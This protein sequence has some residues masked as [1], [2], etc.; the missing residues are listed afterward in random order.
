MQKHEAVPEEQVPSAETVALSSVS[1]FT[2]REEETKSEQEIVHYIHIKCPPESPPFEY[3]QEESKIENDVLTLVFRASLLPSSKDRLIDCWEA[4]LK[5]WHDLGGGKA[6]VGLFQVPEAGSIGSDRGSRLSAP[7][8]LQKIACQDHDG[9]SNDD[10]IS[11]ENATDASHVPSDQIR[12][13][14]AMFGCLD[15]RS[16]SLD[17]NKTESDISSDAGES[18][19]ESE[20]VKPMVEEMQEV[21]RLDNEA[22]SEVGSLSEA[23]S[24]E[25][26]KV[27]LSEVMEPQA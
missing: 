5:E 25:W 22:Q 3:K 9:M 20:P 10:S 19:V 16:D 17:L 27:S 7:A 18:H 2:Y 26:D 4:R 12:N 13:L 1:A 6:P 11:D 14:R 24:Q 8:L 15:G 23:N 21:S